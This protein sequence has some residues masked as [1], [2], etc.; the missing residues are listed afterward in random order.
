MAAKESETKEVNDTFLMFVNINLCYYDF[1][2]K[3]WNIG[4]LVGGAED[5]PVLQN[6]SVVRN[7]LAPLNQPTQLIISGGTN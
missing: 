4:D 1:E 2:Q 7:H 6:A 5:Y 3:R